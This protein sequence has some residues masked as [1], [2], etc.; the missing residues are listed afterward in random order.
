MFHTARQYHQSS[1]SLG[2]RQWSSRWPILVYVLSLNESRT[3]AR[4]RKNRLIGRD[5]KSLWKHERSTRSIYS[6]VKRIYFKKLNKT[7]FPSFSSRTTRGEFLVLLEFKT[8]KLVVPFRWWV[9]RAPLVINKL[10][11]H[12]TSCL[13]ANASAGRLIYSPICSQNTRL[14]FLIRRKI[15]FNFLPL[16]RGNLIRNLRDRGWKRVAISSPS[17]TIN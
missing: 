8:T 16:R 9:S 13:H 4:F 5:K 2:T 11:Q 10:R 17:M 7:T 14:S 12:W 6:W 3:T 15:H 1:T